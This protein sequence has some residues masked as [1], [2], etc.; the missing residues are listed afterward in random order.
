MEEIREDYEDVRQLHYETL[1][2]RRYVT[3]EKARACRLS[4]KFTGEHAPG[5]LDFSSTSR[6]LH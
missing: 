2:D 4:L 5:T 6:V 3:L 1:R